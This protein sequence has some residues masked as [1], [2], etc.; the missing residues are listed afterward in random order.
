MIKDCALD[1]ISVCRLTVQEFGEMHLPPFEHSGKHTAMK[2]K[3]NQTP[4]IC[5]NHKRDLESTSILVDFY[6]NELRSLGLT[7]FRT[8]WPKNNECLHTCFTSIS[9]P[10]WCTLNKH[11]IYK[12]MLYYRPVP[13]L[14]YKSST[15]CTFHRSNTVVNTRLRNNKKT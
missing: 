15:K 13:D 9:S 1:Y 6:E 10:W 3:N 4:I 11:I 12:C 8:D 2:W 7:K 5:F 14:R